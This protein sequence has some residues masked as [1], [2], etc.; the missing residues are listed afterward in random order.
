MFLDVIL[1][2]ISI[3]IKSCIEIIHCF[4]FRS[5]FQTGTP[6]F[7]KDVNN[8]EYNIYKDIFTKIAIG[9]DLTLLKIYKYV[10][11]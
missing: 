7:F 4:D 3:I 6:S 8:N 11:N 1:L 10:T 9:C 5:K 2:L